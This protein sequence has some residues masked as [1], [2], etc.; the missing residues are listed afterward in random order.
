MNTSARYGL[1]GVAFIRQ[2]G[3]R[4]HVLFAIDEGGADCFD[5]EPVLLV[6]HRPGAAPDQLTVEGADALSPHAVELIRAEA[7]ALAAWI[8]G[9]LDASGTFDGQ[10]LLGEAHRFTGSAGA[11]EPVLG[12]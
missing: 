7:A 4:I 6:D 3:G 12:D 10:R 1:H 9:A 8:D 5:G 2:T 11:F